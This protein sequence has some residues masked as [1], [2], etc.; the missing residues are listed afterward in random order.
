MASGVQRG[1]SI[2]EAPR[3]HGRSASARAWSDAGSGS[4]LALAVLGA[5]LVLLLTLLPLSMALSVRQTVAGTADAAA[6]AAAD[7]ASGLLPGFPCAQA[8][9]VARANATSLEAC[10][11]DGLIATVR[12]G[13]TVLGIPVTAL[14]TA[15]PPP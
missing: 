8:E 5:T 2:S 13:S 1:G 14:A 15:G 12:V 4:V 10:H 11:L 7:V 3:P 6:L 9:I